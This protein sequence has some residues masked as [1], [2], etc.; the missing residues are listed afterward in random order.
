MHLTASN[1]EGT[2]REKY[3]HQLDWN[4]AHYIHLVLVILE[5]VPV[6]LSAILSFITCTF[7]HFK[8]VELKVDIRRLTGCNLI[9]I[10]GPLGSHPTSNYI[11][12]TITNIKNHLISNEFQEKNSPKKKSTV[13]R[14]E[15]F[16][17]ELFIRRFV[18][19]LI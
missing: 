3:I 14:F 16:A 5:L 12:M 13:Y 18:C 15:S 17:N 8:T 11:T 2:R 9:L 6:I 4:K 10:C 19:Y 7:A 1:Q